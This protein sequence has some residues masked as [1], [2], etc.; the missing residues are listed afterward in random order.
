MP[1]TFRTSDRALLDPSGVQIDRGYSGAGF[2]GA[3]GR[4]NWAMENVR[5]KGPIPRGLWNIGAARRSANV[6]PV[7]MDLMPK[8]HDAHGRTAFMIHGN[9][10]EN[11]ASKGCV[12]LS[13]PTRE[14]IAASRDRVLNVV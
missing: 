6:G 11:N 12:I 10:K 2:T 13:R 3:E 9:D 8:G 1:W 7:A 14:K 5:G 4:N